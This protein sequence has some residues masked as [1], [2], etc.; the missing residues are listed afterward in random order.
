M[1]I[2]GTYK[3][4]FHLFFRRFFFATTGLETPSFGRA[5]FLFIV[6][7]IFFL[8]IFLLL[9]LTSS[10]D[11]FFLGAGLRFAWMQAPTPNGVPGASPGVTHGA[12]P[13]QQAPQATTGQYGMPQGKQPGQLGQP[14]QPGQPQPQQQ[15]THEDS[16]LKRSLLSFFVRSVQW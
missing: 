15:V 12:V 6:Q 3:S 2:S 14:A 7:S 11:V 5:L 16:N 9:P 13:P 8:P 1:C 10:H 4:V